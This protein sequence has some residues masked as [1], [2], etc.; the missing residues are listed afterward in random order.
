MY[1][2]QKKPNT[3]QK[4]PSASNSSSPLRTRL[5]LLASTGACQGKRSI[6]CALGLCFYIPTF[7]QKNFHDTNMSSS[8]SQNQRR[9]TW[10]HEIALKS[11]PEYLKSI[12]KEQKCT[13]G[14]I[15]NDFYWSCL[16]L[17][18]GGSWWMPQSQS[19]SQ[20]SSDP[21]PHIKA[22]IPAKGSSKEI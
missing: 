2:Q 1:H 22:L 5:Y 6:L 17:R 19:R 18:L 8:C 14:L 11:N 4:N 21:E 9:K 7:V 20:L 15:H 13:N 10:Q 16:S 3:V 12:I